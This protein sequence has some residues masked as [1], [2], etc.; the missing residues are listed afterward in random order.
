[1]NKKSSLPTKVFLGSLLLAVLS[2]AAR[3]VLTL[4]SLDTAYG[5]YKHGD[6]GSVI[7][8]AALAIF[9]LLLVILSL[10]SGK[11]LEERGRPGSGDAVIFASCVSAFLLAASSFLSLY[12]IVIAHADVE[13][14]DIL[15][16]A[17]SLPAIVFFFGLIR[18]GKRRTPAMVFMSFFPTAW[19][20][21]YLIQVYFDSS[22]LITSPNRIFNQLALL[23]AM[24]A[25]LMESRFLL[26]TV[27]KP[28]YLAIASVTPV[29]LLTSAVPNLVLS[30]RLFIGSSD[31]FLCYAVEAAFALFFYARLWSFAHST[32]EPDDEPAAPSEEP[33]PEA[34]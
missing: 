18:S 17:F 15:M 19:C 29:L 27:K 1:M 23:A 22:A 3:I 28:V 33:A 8:H 31:N 10:T 20:A 16:I 5:V 4:T 12:N 25:F 7:H 14:Y 9:C 11:A 21:I 32:Q 2:V 6:A 30:D 34:K 13:I 24:A 26:G